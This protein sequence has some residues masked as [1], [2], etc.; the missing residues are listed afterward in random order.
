MEVDDPFFAFF[1]SQQSWKCKF[2]FSKAGKSDFSCCKKTGKFDF[3]KDFKWTFFCLSTRP[4]IIFQFPFLFHYAHKIG[5]LGKLFRLEDN[6]LYHWQSTEQRTFRNLSPWIQFYRVF[7][8]FLLEK[9]SKEFR[10]E[11]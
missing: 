6:F 10:S 1:P 7:F 5:K 11:Q 8:L 2:C 3:R 9:N 4:M